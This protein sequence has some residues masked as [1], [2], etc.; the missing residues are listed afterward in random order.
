MSPPASDPATPAAS[1]GRPS[2]P[3]EAVLPA[4]RSGAAIWDVDPFDERL[5]A[6]P[7]GYWR[8]LRERAPFV[9]LP[10]YGVWA[11]GRDVHVRA[12]FSD[13]ERFCSSRGVGLADF[14]TEK[15]WR[16]PSL[17]LEADPPA[18]TRTR[19]VLTHAM[20][21]RAVTAVRPAFEAAAAELV[22]RALEAEPVDGVRDLA[23]AFPLRVFP[24]AVGLAGGRR[25]RLL[26]YANLVFNALGPDNGIRRR[27]MAD[28]AGVTEWIAGQCERNALAPNGFGARIYA[29]ADRG[30]IDAHE[31]SLLVR[32]LLSAGI[33]TTVAA[34]GMA[35]LFFAQHP[36]QWQLLRRDASLLRPAF[37]EVLRLGSPVHSFFRTCAVPITLGGTQIGVGQKVLLAIAAANRDPRRWPDPER[38]DITRRAAGHL[39]FGIGIHACVGMRVARLEAEVLLG[40]LAARVASLELAGP[41]RWRPGNALRML[42]ELPLRLRP[43]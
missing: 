38:F 21:Q 4:D 22:G 7:E 42:R 10:K 1:S 2:T 43:A 41:P 13:W 33:D 19:A 25:Q 32:S 35:L 14:A 37:E 26:Q 17:V 28:A 40:E 20:S 15:P 16:P 8:D 31:A 9:W 23:Q 29:A 36:D 6:D 27:A 11:T 30:D 34:L 24:D 3:A 12:I 5:L 18:H 39:A